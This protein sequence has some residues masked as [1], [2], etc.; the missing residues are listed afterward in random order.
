[1][2]A[3]RF[4]VAAAFAVLALGTA[5]PVDAQTFH[6]PATPVKGFWMEA[7]Y[8]DLVDID[9]SF[10]SAT[11]FLSG[12]LPLTSNIRALVDIPYAYSRMEFGDL[13]QSNSVIGNPYLGLEYMTGRM[14]LGA[15]LRA[16]VNS[17]DS[18]S[19][20]DVM[21]F[22]ADFQRSEAFID[23]VVPVYGN[24]SYEYALGRGASIRGQAG[25]VGM[26]YTDDGDAEDGG[27]DALIDY[28]VL[29]TYPMGDARFGLGFYGRWIATADEGDFGENSIHHVAL[30]GD[31]RT[32]GVRPGIFVR[33]PVDKDY[34]DILKSAIGLYLQV[35]VR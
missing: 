24:V 14:V 28:G 3:V 5:S 32:G 20:A 6:M 21:G 12:R 13:E 18:E 8:N 2:S 11:W 29:G 1:M 19:W 15:G 30:S 31:V 34:G 10:P 33:V 4:P 26:L 27:N 35:P 16:P 22:L 17:I 23:Q 9:Q 25:V 7:S